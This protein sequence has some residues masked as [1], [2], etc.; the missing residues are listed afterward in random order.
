MKRLMDLVL[1]V[2]T[3]PL[4]IFL[5][6]L[7]A[8][9]VRI[10]LGSPVLFCQERAGIGGKPF[11]LVKFRTMRE[12]F[13][14]E[15]DP[16]PDEQR[17]SPWGR[18]LRAL[19]LDELPEILNIIRGEMSLVGPRPLPVRY[20]ERYSAEQARRLACLPGLTGWAQIH[21]RNQL[22]WEQRFQLDAWYADH[23][24]FWLDLRIL[25]RTLRLVLSRE[26]ISGPEG[27]TMTEFDG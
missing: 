24:T 11:I 19:S 8:L 16:L 25:G 20:V 18:R 9:M 10:K 23:R 26:G 6:L 14:P 5:L 7:T 4:W 13:G 12:A 27:P 17:L 3:A 15:G 21:G 2:V 22:D 1:I